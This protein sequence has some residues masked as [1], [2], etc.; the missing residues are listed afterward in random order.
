M[1][2][3]IRPRLRF[4][5]PPPSAGP[6]FI[7]RVYVRNLFG[8]IDYNDLRFDQGEGRFVVLFGD[9]GAG[10]TT[11]LHLIYATLSPESNVGLRSF[12]AKTPFSSYGIEFSNGGSIEVIKLD[13]LLGSYR[14]VAL[15]LGQ[16]LDLIMAVD[17]DNDV[18]EQ[19]ST[20]H[21]GSFLR[22]LRVE[23]LFVDHER[24]VRST[25]KFLQDTSESEYLNYFIQTTTGK[26]GERRTRP[27]D[28]SLQ[29]PLAGMV[30]AVRES[31]RTEAFHQGTSGEQNASAVYLEIAKAI[32]RPKKRGPSPDRDKKSIDETL[33]ELERA[34]ESFARYGLLSNYPFQELQQIYA[35]ASRAKKVS[36]SDVLRPFATSVSRRINALQGLFDLLTKFETELNRYLSGKRATV[37]VVHGLT[38]QDKNGPI[39][40]NMLSS[41]EKQLVFLLCAAI[42]A[43]RSRSL[44]LIDEPELSLNYKWQRMIAG[45]LANLSSPST[46]FVTASH[47]IE[48][49]SR[50]ADSS[51]ELHNEAVKSD[52]FKDA[53]TE[54]HD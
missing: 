33:L 51:V 35:G 32:V 22:A 54:T 9:N 47:S 8:H 39:S 40:L 13:G 3:T 26:V 15:G 27:R 52:E 37:H 11:L 18:A 2:T 1:A 6:L 50:Y 17:E 46:Q 30:E 25:Y 20:T 31:F 42:V 7:T 24:Y 14:F 34:T 43:R 23:V 19:P 53:A 12:I 28:R 4:R 38:I 10:K 48:I 5:R 29:F 16:Q 44:I 49:I 36:I 21:L 45:S 41:G